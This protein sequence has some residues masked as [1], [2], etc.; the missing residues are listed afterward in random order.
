MGGFNKIDLN[1]KEESSSN[2]SSADSQISVLKTKKSFKL[3]KKWF[4][5]LIV[6]VLLLL[7][8]VFTVVL[9]AKKTINSAKKTY[10]QAKKAMDAVKKQN[11]ALAGEELVLAKKELLATQK[12][13]KSMSYLKFVPIAKGYYNDADHLLKAGVYGVD[14]AKLLTDSL[15]PY[16]DV[17]GLK[18]Q[19]S[20]VGGSAEQRIQT[21]VLTMGKITPKIDEISKY[22]IE[23]EKEIHAVDPG[24]YPS[25]L[26]G[27]KIKTQLSQ[28]KTVASEGVV[29]VNEAKPLIKVF[30]SL[31]GESK[32]KK[33]LVLFQNDNELRP[34]G[35]FI[36][37][38]AIFRVDRGN[39]Q[40]EGSSDIYAL[41]NA[42]S[43]KPQ[44]PE[45]LKKYLDENIVNLRNVNYSPDYVESMKTF[46]SIYSPNGKANID[47]IIAIDTNVLVSTIKIL[48]DQIS[49]A[50][51]TF[52]TKIDK[53]CD[54]PQVIY[55][56]EDT[57]SRPVN[58]QKSGRKDILGVLLYEI[59]KKALSSS[60]KIYWGPLMQ[61][62]VTQTSQK[63]VLFYLLDK[64][65]QNGI[66]ALNAA[67]RIRPFE[68]DYLHINEA[69]FKGQK[70]NLFIKESVT[71]EVNVKGDGSVEKTI[72]IN[73]KN[74][75]PPS[76]CNLERGG[77]CLNADLRNVVRIYVPKGS[78]L[79]DS[80]GSE[81]KVSTGEEFG[82]TVF[83]G[84]LRVRP[85][86]AAKY[87]ITYKLPFKLEKG[88][89]LPMLIQKQAGTDAFEY[90]TKLNGKKV[91]KFN[92]DTDKEIK[93]EI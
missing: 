89:P 44:A 16:A 32:E 42:I 57:I 29:F 79:I 72:T 60:P 1:T 75:F 37:A 31:L 90:E 63:H 23:A 66:E 68:G 74:S 21:A 70:A 6:V 4:I 41:D 88:S 28:L 9:P 19:G 58:Y 10:T 55:A 14:A 45:I 12:D 51:M 77:L 87:T 65:A 38:Y 35:G 26:G 76:D 78:Q 39:I 61:S 17:L 18:G 85:M 73:Y 81:V 59:M 54:C 84:F 53:R 33:Y 27:S 3:P 67:G 24:H 64:D 82:K 5:P 40:V 50:G 71:Q 25:F 20:F 69:N 47:G 36:T 22:L 2:K 80:K 91:K 43:K 48:D 49:A 34:T 30:P 92:L 93:L 52:T 83:Q 62:L 8:S 11:I 86:G 15:A 56:L 46:Y 7:S 13:L